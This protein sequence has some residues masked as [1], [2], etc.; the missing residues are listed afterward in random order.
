MSSNAH[1]ALIEWPTGHIAGPKSTRRSREA[2]GTGWRRAS[3][4]SCGGSAECEP[5][6]WAWTIR[7]CEIIGRVLRAATYR[8]R[9]I[10][11]ALA[12][13]KTRGRQGTGFL[14]LAGFVPAGTPVSRCLG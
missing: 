11:R 14:S 5:Q 7:R 2:S 8:M 3:V 10:K 9:V 12:R 13:S 1:G 6:D 4:S